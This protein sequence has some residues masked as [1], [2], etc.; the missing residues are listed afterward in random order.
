MG[1]FHPHVALAGPGLSSYHHP[2]KIPSSLMPEGT[3][4]WELTKCWA[5]S[6]LAH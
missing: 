6:Q 4:C 2:A 1:V 3:H 5:W